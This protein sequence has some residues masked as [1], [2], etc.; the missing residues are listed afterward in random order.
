MRWVVT[1]QWHGLT[2]SGRNLPF[3]GSLASSQGQ[4]PQ[5]DEGS[6]ETMGG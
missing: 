3:Q 5:G 4:P 2:N 6:E 1:M